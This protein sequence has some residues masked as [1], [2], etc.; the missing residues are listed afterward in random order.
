V[1]KPDLTKSKCN[2][3]KA[4]ELNRQ[5]QETIRTQ[6]KLIVMKLNLVFMPFMSS[7]Q[8]VY[9]AYSTAPQGHIGK[10]AFK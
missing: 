4:Q 3:V 5:L 8:E 2:Q 10:C 7:R 9:W 1:Q 6:T